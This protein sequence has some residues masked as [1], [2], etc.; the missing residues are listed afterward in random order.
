MK[1]FNRDSLY[2]SIAC[3]VFAEWL[4]LRW[5]APWNSCCFA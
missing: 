1:L 4:H 3:A 5:H 2:G